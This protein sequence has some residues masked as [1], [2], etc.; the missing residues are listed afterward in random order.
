MCQTC[1][2]VPAVGYGMFEGGHV[3]LTFLA[4]GGRCPSRHFPDSGKGPFQFH[5]IQL[6]EPMSLVIWN[7][8]KL[9]SYSWYQPEYCRAPL[10]SKEHMDYKNLSRHPQSSAARGLTPAV[11]SVALFPWGSVLRP[12]FVTF[13]L[14]KVSHQRYQK[15]L[16]HLLGKQPSY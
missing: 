2:Q 9:C 7:N 12:M 5:H 14:S 8:S 3:G 11:C 4:G 10:R 13:L 15:G 1:L 16:K 6:L